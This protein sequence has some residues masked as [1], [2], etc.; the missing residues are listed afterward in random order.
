MKQSNVPS[1][2]IE[3]AESTEKRDIGGGAWGARAPGTSYRKVALWLFLGAFALHL[4]F[5]IQFA[6]SP[7]F[8]VPCLDAQYHNIMAHQILKHELAPEPFFRAPAYGYFLAGLYAVFGLDNYGAVR[9]VHAL[10]GSASVVLLYILGRR[11]FSAR[12]GLLAAISMALYGPLIFQLSDL[13]TTVLE[14]FCLLLFTLLFVHLMHRRTVGDAPLLLAIASGMAVGLWASA[15]PNALI[16]VPVA[17][18]WM[19]GPRLERKFLSVCFAFLVGAAFLPSLITARNAIVGKDPVFIAW[20]GGINLYMANQPNSDGMNMGSPKRYHF[21]EDYEEVVALF[22][23]N[24]AEKTMGRPMRFSEIDRYWRH[25]AGDFWRQQPLAA[26]RL[27]AKKL[28]LIFTRSEIRNITGFD[29]LRT[30]WTPAL[31][32]ACVGFWYAGPFGLL[33]IGLA[34]RAHPASRP[35]GLL[36]ALYLLHLVLFIAADRYRIAIVPLLLL[37]AA[38]A[39]FF[40]FDNIRACNWKGLWVP[41]LALAALLLLVDVQ[42]YQTNP[43]SGWAKDAW[44][45]GIRYN[46]LRKPDKAEVEMRK[47]LKLDPENSDFWLG[48]GESLYYQ[49]K[50]ADAAASFSEGARRAADSSQLLYNLALCKV[51]LGRIPEARDILTNLV[52]QDSEYKLAQDLLRELDSPAKK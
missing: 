16:A 47:A 8:W 30:E 40:L 10:L 27:A 37:F 14:V 29:Y 18:V 25:R 23:K 49:R 33:G 51:E 39:V 11:L 32:L 2:T 38:Y 21:K 31:T 4:L 43:P 22:A 52:R 1:S 24:E 13:H 41:M 48:L 28:V 34:W 12:T 50:F 19:P 44:T 35:L 26:L 45:A 46:K 42:W 3:P 6:Q 36:A 9:V 20:F 17:L 5:L 7:F 15:R